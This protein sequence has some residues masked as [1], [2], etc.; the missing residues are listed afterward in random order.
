MAIISSSR[1]DRR[2]EEL[3]AGWAE[4]V[5]R[6]DEITPDYGFAQSEVELTEAGDVSPETKRC[7]T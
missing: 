6:Q 1:P 7:A 5:D 3:V 4:V 2:T